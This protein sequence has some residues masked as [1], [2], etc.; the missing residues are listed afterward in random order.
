M[1]WDG[2]KG[3]VLVLNAANTTTLNANIDVSGKGF[4]GGRSPN[5]NTTM[6]Y[7]N[8][9]DYYYPKGTAAAA[10]KGESITSIGDP[11]A[12]GKGSPA[13]GGG[14]GNGH[15]S[16]GGGGSNGGAGGFGGYQL[17][18]CGG[19]L[20]DNRGIG[21]KALAYNTAVNKIFM[22]G[23]GGSGH[24][25]NAGGSDMNGGN[26]GGIII[27]KSPIINSGGFKIIAKG[28][29]APQCN[30][31]PIT[32]CHDAS[33]GGGGAGTVLIE[34]ATIIQPTTVD[35]RGGKGGDLV[36]YNPPGASKI[37]PGAGGGA[38]VVWLNNASLPLN[39]VVNNAGGING[40]IVPNANDPYGTTPG[41]DGINLFNLKIPVDVI[42]F[43]PNIDSVRI[44]D[45]A[46]SC[47]N[48]NFKGSGYTNTSSITTWQWFFG[49]GGSA[50]TQNSSHTYANTGNFTVKLIVTDINGCKDS[51]T[52]SQIVT[53]ITTTEIINDYTE[54][55]GFDICKNELIVADA[56]KYNPGDTV[57][58]IQM[59][60][61]I[62]D[63]SNTSNFG[64]VLNYKNAG[65][66]EYNYVKQKTG[67]V[68]QL[69]NL[70]TRQ[71]DI[72]TGKV[73]LVRVPY[74]KSVTFN[75]RLTC[76]P[77]DGSIGGVLAF[78]VKDTL[79]INTDIDVS[80]KGFIG[81]QVINKKIIVFIAMK[82]IIT[83][84]NDQ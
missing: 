41:Q 66:Y 49:D 57:L 19:S 55:L 7:C 3:G 34:N 70:V 64:T 10:D 43:K 2:S 38:G 8:Y 29:D 59:K 17:D 31:I 82:M 25:D 36:I 42:L 75:N 68:I 48:F 28:G 73:Q 84:Q 18:A 83:I 45:S 63:S 21:G 62:I 81:G 37:G 46:T 4:H 12:W 11:I 54:V 40:V 72:P 52:F 79:T 32:L 15:N 39:I 13:N 53:C 69:K 23:G 61:A 74:Y 20:T 30:L 71:Y 47:N 56:S 1:P 76:L 6:L 16:G 33:G 26:G 35:I 50:I 67:N 65:N 5:P 22:G 14:G 9:N 51:T 24:T 44:K 77:W 58:L 60:G 80:G 78:N 27:I